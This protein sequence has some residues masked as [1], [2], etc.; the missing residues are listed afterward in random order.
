MEPEFLRPV[1]HREILVRMLNN[2]R[3]IYFTRRDLRK[4]L[5]VLDLLLTVPPR[6]T[7]LLRERALVRLN[8]DQYLGAAQ[9]LANYLKFEPGA[10]DAED[11][12]ETLEMV[13]QLLSRL[14]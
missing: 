6:S 4:G 7:E 13:R 14:N 3:Q 9:D 2:L 12:R 10:A 1:T 11:V 5:A 8:L